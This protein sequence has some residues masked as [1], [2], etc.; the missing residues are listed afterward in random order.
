[1][2]AL[3][4]ANAGMMISLSN[5]QNNTCELCEDLIRNATNIIQDFTRFQSRS[6]GTF[7]VLSSNSSVPKQNVRALADVCYVGAS[8]GFLSDSIQLLPKELRNEMVNFFFEE[9]LGN[10]WPRAISF[11]DSISENITC[12]E[13]CTTLDLVAMSRL[14]IDW[15]IWWSCRSRC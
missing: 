1:M 10:G 14:D 6:D 11:K 4:I 5:L 13:N 12:V 8:L 7:D 3:Q 15:S 9:L 2:P